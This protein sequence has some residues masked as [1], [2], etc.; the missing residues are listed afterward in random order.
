MPSLATVERGLGVGC[1]TFTKK[2]ESDRGARGRQR[3]ASVSSQGVGPTR[4]LHGNTTLGPRQNF[5][6]APSHEASGLAISKPRR[7]KLPRKACVVGGL[8]LASRIQHWL[9]AGRRSFMSGREMQVDQ[10]W[11]VCRSY[12]MRG[13][14]IRPYE[15]PYFRPPS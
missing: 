2:E 6:S 14:T 12:L 15:T 8:S 10:C 9:Q 5:L 11:L 7:R 13:R 4:A 3:A 1:A